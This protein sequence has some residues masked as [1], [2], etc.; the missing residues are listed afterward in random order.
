MTEFRHDSNWRSGCTLSDD[1]RAAS[2]AALFYLDGTVIAAPSAHLLSVRY[3]RSQND[4]LNGYPSAGQCWGGGSQKGSL[5]PSVSVHDN[6]FSA[7]YKVADQ[8]PSP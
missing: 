4:L 6:L 3:C 1:T 8:R 5:R 7:P 2:Q